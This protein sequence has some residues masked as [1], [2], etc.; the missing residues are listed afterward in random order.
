MFRVTLTLR[1]IGQNDYTV[2]ESGQQIG[3]IRYASERTPGI[4]YWHIQVHIPD[5]NTMGTA[6][7][8][9]KAKAEFKSGWEAFKTRHGPEKLAEAYR[10]M[11]IR[12]G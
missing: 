1:S 11:S 9:D 10:A 6:Q 4:W 3:R 8:L 2:H 12:G 5:T 7:T